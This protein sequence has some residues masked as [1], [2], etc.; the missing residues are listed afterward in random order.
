MT[1][2]ER[3]TEIKRRADEAAVRSG[4]NPSDVRLVAVTKTHGAAEINEAIAAGATDIGENR[5][6]SCSKNTIVW[7]LSAGTLSATCRPT[8]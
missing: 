1:I 8:K 4:R 5:V 6:R 2:D 3:Y 7:I